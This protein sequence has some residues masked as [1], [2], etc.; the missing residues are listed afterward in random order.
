MVVRRDAL[1]ATGWIDRQLLADR[2]GSELISGGDVEIGLRLRT[3]FELWYTPRC[4]LRHVVQAHRTTRS[5]LARLVY[6][7]GASNF[8]GDTMQWQ[9]SER[10]WVLAAAVRSHR[11][12]RA[13]LEAAVGVA[14][15]RRDPADVTI[16][17]SFLRGWWS[18]IRAF[19]AATQ[20]RRAEL[21]GLAASPPR[22]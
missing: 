16:A 9:G 21:V 1:A 14:R 13:V 20:D 12:A 22:R 10:S 19:L 18:G 8:L 2:T 5:Y 3:Q 11:F 7:L 15:G 6:G 4:R 17:F